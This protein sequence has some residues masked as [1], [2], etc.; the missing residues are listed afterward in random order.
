MAHHSR[1][2]I[3]ERDL[4]CGAPRAG[5]LLIV[6]ATRVNTAFASVKT[7]SKGAPAISA[8]FP[9]TLHAHGISIVRERQ[10]VQVNVVRICIHISVHLIIDG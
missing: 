4:G 5:W 9:A 3:D 2:T 10:I 1:R 6:H 7:P 8:R